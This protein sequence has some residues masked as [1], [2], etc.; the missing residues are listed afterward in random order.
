M[1]QLKSCGFKEI[2]VIESGAQNLENYSFIKTITSPL[3]NKGFQMNLGAQNVDSE[4]ILFLHA[5]VEI[6]DSFFFHLKRYISAEFKCGNFYL[7]FSNRHWFLKVNE[8]FSKSKA[9]AF[10]FGD[11]GLLIKTKI[12]NSVGG[13]NPSLFYMEG[14][15]IISRLRKKHEFQKIPLTLT[16]SSRKYDEIGIYKLQFIYYIIYL[17]TVLG[18]SQKRVIQFFPSIFKNKN[19]LI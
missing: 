4:F 12:F 15:E 9:Q 3:N 10:Q 1:Q 2:I 18:I 5:D 13:F 6:S 17:L 14:N 16:V 19:P 7:K 11:Q 8:K